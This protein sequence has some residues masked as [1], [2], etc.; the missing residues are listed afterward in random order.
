MTG[1]AWVKK[2]IKKFYPIPNFCHQCGH[3]AEIF[4][5]ADDLWNAVVKP[6]EEEIIL[7]LRC[8]DKLARSQD[9]LTF[10]KGNFDFS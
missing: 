1:L 5:V 2:I 9:I 10:W 6:E 8:F 3:W 7:C 4:N